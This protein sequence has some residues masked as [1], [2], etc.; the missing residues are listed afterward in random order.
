MKIRIR[1]VHIKPA[2]VGNTQPLLNRLGHL[3]TSAKP[4][5]KPLPISF[6]ESLN[7]TSPME[8]RLVAIETQRAQAAARAYVNMLPPR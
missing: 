8:E 3:T 1:N 6:G 7:V 5:P 2:T 4:L